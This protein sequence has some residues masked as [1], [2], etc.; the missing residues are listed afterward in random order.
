MDPRKVKVVTALLFLITSVIILIAG[1]SRILRVTAVI[2]IAICCC[3]IIYNYLPSTMRHRISVIRTRLSILLYCTFMI[4]ALIITDNDVWRYFILLYMTLSTGAFAVQ[5]LRLNGKLIVAANQDT[6]TDISTWF[7]VT[8]ILF[9]L[10]YLLFASRLSFTQYI[11][12]W[13]LGIFPL[14]IAIYLAYSIYRN[15]SIAR[16]GYILTAI[17]LATCGSVYFQLLPD[18]DLWT[19]YVVLVATATGTLLFQSYICLRHYPRPDGAM[20]VVFIMLLIKGIEVCSHLPEIS[21]HI[22]QLFHS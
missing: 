7:I 16:M 15:K 3:D 4:V 12:R 19:L 13:T 17:S 14:L 10:S 20:A 2:M 21:G 9:I 18:I 6:K 1:D 22:Q 11:W 5:Q 8:T